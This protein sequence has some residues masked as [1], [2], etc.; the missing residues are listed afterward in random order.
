MVLYILINVCFFL[1]EMATHKREND[2][3]VTNIL[4][5]HEVEKLIT[6]YEK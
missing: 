4:D 1:V 6:E 2:H 3:T 5:K